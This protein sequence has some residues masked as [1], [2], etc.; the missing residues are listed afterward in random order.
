M[1]EQK[2]SGSLQDPSTGQGR[3]L[4]SAG[5]RNLR[6]KGCSQVSEEAK[7]EDLFC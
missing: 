4:S 1:E 3:S 6:S 2:Q 7:E 5:G